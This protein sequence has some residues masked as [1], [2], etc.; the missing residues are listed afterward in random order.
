[1]N[2]TEISEKVGFS[3]SRYFSTMFKRYTGKTPS[4]YKEEH[5]KSMKTEPDNE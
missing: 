5:R 3:S 1:M 2:F 4:Q